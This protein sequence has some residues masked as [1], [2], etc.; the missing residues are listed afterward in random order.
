MNKKRR[1][2][3]CCAAMTSCIRE[4]EAALR[5]IP[6]LR[7]YKIAILDG[8]SSGLVIRYCPW[9][10]SK[11]PSSLRE[12]WFA[13]IESLGLN[14]WEGAVPSEYRSE[15]WWRNWLATPSGESP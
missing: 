11:L 9:C 15:K 14:P 1:N 5:Y 6:Y 12:S 3:H 7:E 13:R 10:R 4:G 2:H 8:G